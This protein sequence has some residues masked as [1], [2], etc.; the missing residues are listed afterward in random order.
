[1]LIQ[2]LSRAELFREKMFGVF[3]LVSI[4][5]GVRISCEHVGLNDYS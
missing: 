4:V 2:W 1:M 3:L 5:F